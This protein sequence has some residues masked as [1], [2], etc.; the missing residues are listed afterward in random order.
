MHV[1]SRASG[2]MVCCSTEVFP[3]PSF[4]SG[5]SKKRITQACSRLTENHGPWNPMSSRGLRQDSSGPNEERHDRKA[6]QSPN[7]VRAKRQRN[8]ASERW[9]PGDLYVRR[10]C[11]WLRSPAAEPELKLS[12]LDIHPYVAQNFPFFRCSTPRRGPPQ[13]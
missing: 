9:K 12:V 10:T 6:R 5:T 1:H 8:S 2:S 4:E 3:S 13:H 7:P 11:G